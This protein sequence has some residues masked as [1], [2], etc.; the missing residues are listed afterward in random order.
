[1][2][3]RINQELALIR[4]RFPRVGYYEEGH[5]VLI[6]SYP[7]PDEWNRDTTDVAFQIQNGYP[8]TPPYG[9]YVP[10]GIR[11]QGGVPG[12]YKEPVANKPPLEGAWGV[13]SW[14]PADRDWMPTNDIR[15]GANLLN[16]VLGFSDRFREGK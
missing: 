5:W 1:M 2:Q 11:F 12:N 8:G 4:H 7:L 14:A 9:I 10:S 13:F 6:P 15:K 16:W 3:E